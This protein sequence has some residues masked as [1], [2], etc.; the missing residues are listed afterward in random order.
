MHI[1]EDYFED[2]GIENEDIIEDDIL[3]VEGTKIEN[4]QK[5]PEQYS[6]NITIG[7]KNIDKD[8][9]FFQT[10][11]IPRIFKRLDAILDFYG[12]EHS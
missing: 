4:A 2:L 12:I 10:S 1:N 3:D 8:T 7:I 9:T 11:L 5:L 6:H